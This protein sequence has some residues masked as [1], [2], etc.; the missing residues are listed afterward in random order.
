MRIMK[1]IILMIGFIIF[2]VNFLSAEIINQRQTPLPTQL[3]NSTKP[4]NTSEDLKKISSL[5]IPFI[6]NEGQIKSQDVK[7]YTKT[8]IGNV[9]I[10]DKGELIYNIITPKDYIGTDTILLSNGSPQ[11]FNYFI[12]E[13]P[14]IKTTGSNSITVEGLELAETIVNSF[15]G[16]K[17]D[18]RSNVSTYKLITLGNIWEGITFNLKANQKNIEKL[19]IIYPNGNVNS[20]R[21]AIEGTK[22]LALTESGELTL[23]TSQGNTQFTQPI[24]YQEINGI[25][26]RIDVSY[27]IINDSTYGFKVGNYDHSIPLIIDPL[28][29]STYCGGNGEDAY[30]CVIRDNLNYVI[31]AGYSDSFNVLFPTTAGS[32]QPSL[33]IPIP[34]TYFLYDGV[35]TEFSP[36]LTTTWSSTYFGTFTKNEFCN[37]IALDNANPQNIFVTGTAGGGALPETTSTTPTTTGVYDTTFNGGNDVFVAR[38]GRNGSNN[39]NT[40]SAYTYL[41]STGNDYGYAIRVDTVPTPQI[42]YVAGIAGNSTFPAVGGA[43]TTFGG[44]TEGFIA[45]LNNALTPGAFACSY[46][47]GSANDACYGLAIVDTA[48]N[49]VVTGNT[50]SPD[51]PTTSGTYKSSPPVGDADV[52]V[53]KFSNGLT[54]VVNSTLIG[55]NGYDT[56][57]A[58]ATDQFNNIYV[59]GETQSS[60]FP[61]SCTALSSYSGSGDAFITKFNS[62]LTATLASRLLGGTNRDIGYSLAVSGTGQTGQIFL[63]GYTSSLDFPTQPVILSPFDTALSGNSDAFIARLDIAT[64]NL[65]SST[66]IGGSGVELGLPA[67]DI[68]ARGGIIIDIATLTTTP[69]AGTTVLTFV[70][71]TNSLNFPLVNPM[72]TT[73]PSP[74][75][76]L[77]NGNVYVGGNC[78]TFVSRITPE[79]GLNPS[80]VTIPALAPATIL[81]PSNGTVDQI[82]SPILQ[83]NAPSNA[84]SSTIRYAIYLSSPYSAQVELTVGA[85]TNYLPAPELFEDGTPYYWQIISIDNYV[86]GS[87]TYTRC[88]WSSISRFTTAGYRAGNDPVI[89]TTDNAG[90][91]GDPFAPR[92]SF[93]KP[94]GSCFIATAVYGSPTHPN[95][96]ALKSF[97]DTYLLTNLYGRYAVKWY[98]K[99]SPGIAEYIKHSTLLSATFKLGLSPV[100]YLLRYPV[101]IVVF[102]IIL[103]ILSVLYLTKIIIP[104][105]IKK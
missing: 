90:S 75:T 13:K 102:L 11:P 62:G 100:T 93:T 66:Y 86:S 91:S 23:I 31:A 17:E 83:W 43:D 61:V 95:V 39:I 77:F 55:G 26:N 9:F 14:I 63:Y 12:K 51:F 32:F 67:A 103:S 85:I 58:I 84:I 57:Y 73:R 40:L 94:L 54:S 41:G 92:D 64:L 33:S 98:Y 69:L 65:E 60:D 76:G 22:S 68:I 44:G 56:A 20:I 6:K 50:A 48:R 38:F 59:T 7:F 87:I 78:D 46:V 27:L 49:I 89:T 2:A 16:P 105:Y 47:G 15:V 74:Y 24:A 4:S 99:I 52:F 71:T 19:F 80:S 10:T 18:W 88:S 35:I 29:S 8:L 5:Q 101:L 25:R 21:F 30:T 96:M 81:S 104:A 28:L 97:R 70:G 79:L 82:I 36:G 34:F 72:D 45:R 3:N 1:N 53:S 37:A 42:V